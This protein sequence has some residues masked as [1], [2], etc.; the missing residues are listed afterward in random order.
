[1][2]KLKVKKTE[3]E[4]IEIIDEIVNNDL[5][6]K[7]IIF[8]EG[9]DYFCSWKDYKPENEEIISCFNDRFNDGKTWQ[10]YKK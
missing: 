3:I 10:D 5:Y 6:Y 7:V 2:G 9:Y 8:V 4:S 1:M